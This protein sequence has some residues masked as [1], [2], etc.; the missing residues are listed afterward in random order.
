M[1]PAV[2]HQPGRYEVGR[3]PRHLKSEP[4]VAIPTGGRHQW[5][6]CNEFSTRVTAQHPHVCP[7]AR[8]VP[9]HLVCHGCG[10]RLRHARTGYSLRRESGMALGY[11]R[12]HAGRRPYRRRASP[13]LARGRSSRRFCNGLASGA[14]W[15]VSAGVPTAFMSMANSVLEAG[16][17]WRTVC[18]CFALIG[19]YLAYAGWKPTPSGPMSQAAISTPDLPRAA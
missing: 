8:P 14:A 12:F 2:A 18:V 6:Y 17:L 5:R 11:R 9:R 13:V 4:R 16:G 15:A 3:H 19:L 10:P 1:A 7:G